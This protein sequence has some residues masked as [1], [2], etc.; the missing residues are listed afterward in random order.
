MKFFLRG[1]RVCC[2]R[3]C[4]GGGDW[5]IEVLHFL[6]LFYY[7]FHSLCLYWLFSIFSRS[8]HSEISMNC[9]SHSLHISEFCPSYWNY[10]HYKKFPC[11][12]LI[13][14]FL[15]VNWQHSFSNFLLISL[16]RTWTDSHYQNPSLP[17]LFTFYRFSTFSH[18][19]C[20]SDLLAP[21]S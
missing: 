1:F 3:E 10:K 18:F 6:G 16:V 7:L 11:S 17:N 4:S 20:L 13:S 9:I 5:V 15:S 14:L 21:T 12:Y 8:Y 2:V 19:S